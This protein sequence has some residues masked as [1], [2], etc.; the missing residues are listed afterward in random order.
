M[1]TVY[2]AGYIRWYD[3][4]QI[5]LTLPKYTGADFDWGTTHTKEKFCLRNK[6]CVIY[7]YV[8]DQALHISAALG[9]LELSDHSS[10]VSKIMYASCLQLDPL[11]YFS[12]ILGKN[13]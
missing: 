5:F 10:T 12:S 7:Q 13:S 1:L 3:T 2:M 11:L 8:N 4:P 9:I 6:S